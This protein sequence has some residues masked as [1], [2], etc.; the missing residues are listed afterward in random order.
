M[1]GKG[2]DR[3]WD[4]WMASPTQ[5]TWVWVSSGT[6]W[7][8]G[9]PGVPQSMGLQRVRHDWAT[10]LNWTYPQEFV[11][12]SLSFMIFS[13]SE[14]PS[15]YTAIL[16]ACLDQLYGFDI[17]IAIDSTSK[18]QQEEHNGSWP[19]GMQRRLQWSQSEGVLGLR[20]GLWG[21]KPISTLSW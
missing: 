18:G 21:Q 10:E 15:L 13:S 5:W 3:G 12:S 9:R 17:L 1:G 11:T 6:W 7:L 2:D 14:I 4:G 19:P 8:T 20:N 16:N